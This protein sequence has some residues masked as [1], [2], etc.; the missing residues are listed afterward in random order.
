MK[1][2]HLLLFMVVLLTATICSFSQVNTE[3]NTLTSD[4]DEKAYAK[5]LQ[6]SKAYNF[7]RRANQQ[8]GNIDPQ[9]VIRAM[10]QVE[11]LKRNKSGNP[12]NLSWDELGPNNYPGRIRAFLV[13]NESSGL[14]F[15]G[16]EAGGL[17]KSSIGGL[18]W[19]KIT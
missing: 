13:D 1:N 3:N 5:A 11:A 19:E 9:D 18:F 15:A 12:Y 6:E 4:Q 7:S 8:T 14:L 16:S 10:D 17:W 2:K